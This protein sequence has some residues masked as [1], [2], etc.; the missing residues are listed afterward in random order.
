VACN[1][2]I[3]IE[4]ACAEAWDHSDVRPHCR[5][6]YPSWLYLVEIWFARIE[7]DVIARRVFTSAKDLARKLMRDIRHYN[8]NPKPIK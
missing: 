3:G 6:I 1:S 4:Q 8:R 5:P 2:A 7:R